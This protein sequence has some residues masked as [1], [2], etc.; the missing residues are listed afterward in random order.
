[1]GR[2]A[3]ASGESVCDRQGVILPIA[4]AVF[5]VASGPQALPLKPCVLQRTVH[6]RCGTLAVP[7]D[8][9]TSSG[10]KIKVFVGVLRAYGPKPHAAPIFWLAG[11]PGGAAASD[12][13]AFAQYVFVGANRDRDIVLVDQRG[14]GK[15]AL[16]VCPPGGVADPADEAS[17]RAYV[18]N[19]LRVIGRDP[20]LYTTGPAMDDVDAVRRALGYKRVVLYGGSYGGTAA[21]V[22]IA[23]HPTHVAAAVLDGATLLDVPIWERM[24]LTTQMAFDRLAARCSADLVCRTV[25]PDVAGDLHVVFARLRAAPI[26]VPGSTSAATFDVADAQDTVRTLLRAPATAARVPLILHRAAAGDYSE[27]LAQWASSTAG[28]DAGAKL[29]YWAIRCGEGWS[30][31]DPAE[32]ARVGS[33]TEFLEAALASS[34]VQAF[35]CGILGPP[36]PARD[37]GVVP[38]SRL[39]VLFL[40]G[41]MDP[42][43]PLENV[44]AAPRSLP[45]AQILVVPGAGHGSV[46]HG[47][48]S[49]VATRFFKNHRLTSSDRACAA[50][51]VP[52]PFATN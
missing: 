22:F 19:C 35:V 34:R 5:A 21:Q 28:D 11:G 20:R 16:L 52:P 51:V 14:V 9:R 32:I 7:E 36:L 43:D 44:A 50:K 13:A 1:M 40:V 33:G 18:Q 2:C 37:T 15:S 17:A 41:G 3:D 48:L 29:M 42:Q 25:V 10:R 45:N 12:D 24:P 38:R 30:R 49:G 8:R 31:D 39:P 23:R 27:L 6:A 47:C 4:A 26:P 46:Q